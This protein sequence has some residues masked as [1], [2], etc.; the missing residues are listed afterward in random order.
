MGTAVANPARL[1]ATL[2]LALRARPAGP[3]VV[4]LRYAAY[5]L[6][7]MILAEFLH[8]RGIV[9]AHN[10]L[11]DSSGT[12]TMLAAKL[13]GIPF[14]M[15]LHGPEVFD[16]A[17]I[18]RLDVKIA[19]ARSTVCISR[20]GR[21]KALRHCLTEHSWKVVTIPCGITFAEYATDNVRTGRKL[22]FVG[23]LVPRKGVH[24]LV[25][26]LAMARNCGIAAELDI[27]GEGPEYP[28][29]QSLVADRGLGDF[30]VFRGSLGEDG[31]ANAMSKADVLVVP[32]LSEG[33]P[34]V[35]MEAMASGLPVIASDIDGIPELVRDAETGF[36]VPPG[37]SQKLAQALVRLLANPDLARSMGARGRMNVKERYDA[38]R[39]A[40]ALRRIFAQGATSV[41]F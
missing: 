38:E 30:V 40:H 16:A 3:I 17:D 12:V 18:W 26:A 14:S 27:V 10:H 5:F 21:E 35:I 37:D 22:L 34:V 1:L 32:S 13:V 9:H 33:L 20:D 31:V 41:L 6:E 19:H 23:R 2:S 29:L 8:R 39:S 28:L 7:A 11:G 24:V 15:T 36:L 25:E 4:Y